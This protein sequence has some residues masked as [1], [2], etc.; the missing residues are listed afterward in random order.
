MLSPSTIL[1]L[2]RVPQHAQEQVSV[3]PAGRANAPLA[4][5]AHR[6]SSA[7][8]AS[9][10]PTAK[11]AHPIAIVVTKEF[12]GLDDASSQQY[13]TLRQLATV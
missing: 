4:S 2:W 13:R 11:H 9:L 3:L 12:R 6:V 7:S 10:D 5:Q 8:L 1:S